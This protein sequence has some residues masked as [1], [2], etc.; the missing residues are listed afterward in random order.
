MG[1]SRVEPPTTFIVIVTVFVPLFPSCP[2][3]VLSHPVRTRCQRCLLCALRV[4][5]KRIVLLW[6]QVFARTYK[7]AIRESLTTLILKL[8]FF[9]LSLQKGCPTWNPWDWILP[10][11]CCSSY[12]LRCTLTMVP[13]EYQPMWWSSWLGSSLPYSSHPWDGGDLIPIRISQP[14][15]EERHEEIR[16]SA[17]VATKHGSI[18]KKWRWRSGQKRSKPS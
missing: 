10:R 14:I 2:N 6:Y 15:E 17:G 7:Q 16:A 18:L 4:G 9:S 13:N 11:L 8:R 12:R 3:F 1:V 5:S